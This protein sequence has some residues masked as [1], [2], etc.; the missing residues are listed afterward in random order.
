MEIWMMGMLAAVWLGVGAQTVLL[1]MA[2]R[3]RDMQQSP[4]A[5]QE[6]EEEQELRR[7]A[8]ESQRQYEQGFVNLMRYDGSPGRKE[9]DRQ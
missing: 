4:P 2:L 8:A 7:L 3:H 9:R 6:T 5:A 1:A